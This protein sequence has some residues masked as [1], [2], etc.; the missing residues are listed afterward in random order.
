MS[1]RVNVWPL[2]TPEKTS[3]QVESFLVRSAISLR[4]RKAANADRVDNFDWCHTAVESEAAAAPLPKRDVTGAEKAR[5]RERERGRFR[6]PER[7]RNRTG[8]P[9]T[10]LEPDT[11]DASATMS[12]VPLAV[13]DLS[14]PKL[15]FVLR[16]GGRRE[17]KG[18]VV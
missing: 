9:G 1:Y 4:W 7:L 18:A 10:A 6:G 15:C 14:T 17:A 5:E 11:V 12:R 3:Q 13:L 2:T 8:R 16:A